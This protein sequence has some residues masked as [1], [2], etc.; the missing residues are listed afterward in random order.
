MATRLYTY[1]LI[2]SV[3]AFSGRMHILPVRDTH[4]L[5]RGSAAAEWE[6]IPRDARVFI[7]CLCK[8]PELGS[9]LSCSHSQ[10]RGSKPGPQQSPST[11]E[12]SAVCFAELGICLAQQST[13]QSP[14]LLMTYAWSEV[15]PSGLPQ[16]LDPS[17]A[18]PCCQHIILNPWGTRGPWPITVGISVCPPRSSLC[19][20]RLN[21][22]ATGSWSLRC[23]SHQWPRG[24]LRKGSSA[25]RV[26]CA[27]VHG[28]AAS[29]TTTK[30]AGW[31]AGSGCVTAQKPPRDSAARVGLCPRGLLSHRKAGMFS[32]AKCRDP[33]VILTVNQ[34]TLNTRKR[35]SSKLLSWPPS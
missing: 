26:H 14:G 9:Q 31:R 10:M 20:V 29:V 5:L 1:I 35:F 15:I 3:K 7:A 32:A 21:C 24:I 12:A 17:L 33:P 23:G 6:H 25:G 16:G 11:G 19:L 28:P 22:T 30:A 34:M 13:E 4:L 18:L 27:V 8:N 2:C